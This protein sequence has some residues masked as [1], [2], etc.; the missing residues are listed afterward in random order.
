MFSF[1]NLC[2]AEDIATS[3]SNCGKIML[4]GQR[5]KCYD[6]IRD[7]M[8]EQKQP[9]AN[10]APNKTQNSAY[11]PINFI[12][13]QLDISNL[14]GKKIVITAK[15]GYNSKTGII[16][17]NENPS[18]NQ[19][20]EIYSISLFPKETRKLLLQRCSSNFCRARVFG[21]VRRVGYDKVVIDAEQIDIIK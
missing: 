21:T 18:R 19:L 9:A 3:I 12:D 14:I 8:V 17:E 16:A 1:V 6:K 15:F 5:L 11:Q 7:G 10:P 13:L 20:M 4:N 2:Q